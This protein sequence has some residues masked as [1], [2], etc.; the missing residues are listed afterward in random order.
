VPN[1]NVH[2]D[3]NLNSNSDRHGY[4]YA[5]AYSCCYCDCDCDCGAEVYPDA[6]AA[7]DATAT[8]ITCSIFVG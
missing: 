3:A 2:T 8:S 1:G 4:I 5:Y 6:K 7:P